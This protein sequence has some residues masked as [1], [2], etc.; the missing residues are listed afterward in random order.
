MKSE[1]LECKKRTEIVALLRL[2]HDNPGVSMSA[3][4]E[5]VT[6]IAHST[7]LTRLN[8]C[9]TDGVVEFDRGS[10]SFR[11]YRL[12]EEFSRALSKDGDEITDQ[13]IADVYDDFMK[14]HRDRP[15][16]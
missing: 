7:I 12:T 8:R 6:S 4:C 1:K 13:L 16:A 3:I 11:Y 9:Q 2:I 10:G 5:A 14:Q 15:I